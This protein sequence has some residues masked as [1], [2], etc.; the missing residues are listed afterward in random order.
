MSVSIIPEN[1][2]NDEVL[3]RE[4]DTLCSISEP[5]YLICIKALVLLDR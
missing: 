4:D 3:L 2:K 5:Y 1:L